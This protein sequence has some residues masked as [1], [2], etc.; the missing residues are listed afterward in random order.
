MSV[1]VRTSVLT[2]NGPC[3][4]RACR[5]CAADPV[6]Y[7]CEFDGAAKTA[8]LAD[9]RE[10]MQA[11]IAARGGFR[12]KPRV[13]ARVLSDAWVNQML[14]RFGNNLCHADSILSVIAEELWPS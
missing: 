2:Q 8:L 13:V 4:W 12:P 10:Y 7:R 6:G 5:R 11:L 1:V 3:L 14:A 9:M